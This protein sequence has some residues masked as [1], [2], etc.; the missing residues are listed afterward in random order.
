[1]A[2][3]YLRY[4]VSFQN[5]TGHLKAERITLTEAVAY[6]KQ[7][8]GIEVRAETN[9]SFIKKWANEIKKFK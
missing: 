5:V 9:V 2:A 7:L 3:D 6:A 1:M 4:Q 8:T